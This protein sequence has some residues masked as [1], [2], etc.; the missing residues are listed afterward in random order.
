MASNRV[1]TCIGQGEVPEDLDIRCLLS[2]RP[3]SNEFLLD[4]K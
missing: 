3:L 4:K 1:Y 2:V